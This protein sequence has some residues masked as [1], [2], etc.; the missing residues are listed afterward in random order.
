MPDK[1]MKRNVLSY[2]TP[3]DQPV[4]NSLLAIASIVIAWFSVPVTVL[5]DFDPGMTPAQSQTQFRMLLALAVLCGAAAMTLAWLSC[6]HQH[7]RRN[8]PYVA[9]ALSALAMLFALWRF[10]IGR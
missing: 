7:R 9:I 2:A 10:S 3:Q 1:E 6:R 5:A 4:G 8:L